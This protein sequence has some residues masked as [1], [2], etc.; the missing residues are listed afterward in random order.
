MLLICIIICTLFYVYQGFRLAI[1][2]SEEKRYLREVIEYHDQN[3]ADII[4]EMIDNEYDT[5]QVKHYRDLLQ[6]HEDM[7]D[8]YQNS[9]ANNTYSWS[10]TNENIILVIFIF[11]VISFLLTFKI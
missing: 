4:K 2:E 1:F 5:S 11:L 6:S 10:A 8:L 3:S 9:Y 7:R